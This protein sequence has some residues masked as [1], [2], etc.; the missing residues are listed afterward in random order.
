[1]TLHAEQAALA[2]EAAHGE[3]E[4]IAIAATSNEPIG[5]KSYPC[6]MCKQLLWESRRRS[7]LPM[8]I[9]VFDQFGSVEELNLDDIM[10]YA[11]PSEDR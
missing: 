8:E 3:G 1:M 5:A 6:H 9:I 2:H 11:W 10:N 7:G 4:I